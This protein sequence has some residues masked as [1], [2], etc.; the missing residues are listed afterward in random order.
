MLNDWVKKCLGIKQAYRYDG[1]IMYAFNL[2]SN[3]QDVETLNT[4][5]A[6]RQVLLLLEGV[7]RS[8]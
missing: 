1:R 2:A 5:F 7:M 3:C 4:K 6:I 8:N